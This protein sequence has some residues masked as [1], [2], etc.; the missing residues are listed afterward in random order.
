LVYTITMDKQAILKRV[1]K[2]INAIS[3]SKHSVE[4]CKDNFVEVINSRYI[5]DIY[6]AFD[7]MDDKEL[8]KYISGILDI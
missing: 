2:R 8:D 6:E 1:T 7:S 4:F 3:G 5:G